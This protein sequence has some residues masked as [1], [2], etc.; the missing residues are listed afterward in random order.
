MA[1]KTDPFGNARPVDV[2]KQLEKDKEI[3]RKLAEQRKQDRLRSSDNNNENRRT[4]ST[5]KTARQ[6]KGDK[7]MPKQKE[8]TFKIE[9]KSKFNGLGLDDEMDSSNSEEDSNEDNVEEEEEDDENQA[10]DELDLE[11]VEDPANQD[12]TAEVE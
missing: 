1:N 10:T 5:E 8:S 12:W 11:P 6:P 7:P 9:T 2:S 4:V 3:E